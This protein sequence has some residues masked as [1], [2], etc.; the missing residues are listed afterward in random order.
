MQSSVNGVFILPLSK[1]YTTATNTIV[2]ACS[3]C[4]KWCLTM[5]QQTQISF[6]ISFGYVLANSIQFNI[7]Y[8]QTKG[9][10]T[11]QR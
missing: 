11:Q 5:N 3:V 1:I 6:W 10:L 9:S 7:N 8:R 4:W 2:W